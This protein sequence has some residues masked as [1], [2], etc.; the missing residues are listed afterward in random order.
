[1]NQ[2]A[3]IVGRVTHEHAHLAFDEIINENKGKKFAFVC[4]R[5]KDRDRAVAVK[6][7]LLETLLGKNREQLKTGL[8]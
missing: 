7:S 3:K 8:F 5:L 4:D 1:M 2:N 6:V